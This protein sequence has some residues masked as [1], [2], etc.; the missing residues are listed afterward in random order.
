[1]YPHKTNK[2]IHCI[3]AFSTVLFAEAQY[4]KQDATEVI[5]V[6][7][8]YVTVLRTTFLEDPSLEETFHFVLETVFGQLVVLYHAFTDIL[9]PV[10]VHL[11][12]VVP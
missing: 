9:D 12:V 4:R 10:E 6:Q 11:V 1:L 7:H 5:P 2:I 8:H 3:L